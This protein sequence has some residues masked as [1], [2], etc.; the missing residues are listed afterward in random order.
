[1]E[2]VARAR[3]SRMPAFCTGAFGKLDWPRSA[4]LMR[5][6]AAA[7]WSDS[8]AEEARRVHAKHIPLA[9][10]AKQQNADRTQAVWPHHCGI[11]SALTKRLNELTP[12][13]D[14]MMML[15][16]A[17]KAILARSTEKV[18]CQA[19]PEEKGNPPAHPSSEG[20]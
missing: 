16:A 18:P 13:T 10:A 2:A 4:A 5:A 7:A 20:V 9:S 11:F 14:T 19:P 8:T 17:N 15:R 1:M 12:W 3:V 6:A